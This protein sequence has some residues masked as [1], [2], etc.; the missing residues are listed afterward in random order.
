MNA[1]PFA[2]AAAIA[3]AGLVAYTHFVMLL[4]IKERAERNGHGHRHAA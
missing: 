1:R 4:G 2:R 3:G